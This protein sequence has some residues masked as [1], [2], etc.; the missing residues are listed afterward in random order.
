M[1]AHQENGVNQ[2]TSESTTDLSQRT[3]NGQG[4]AP[5]ADGSNLDKVRDILFGNQ[6]REYDKRFSRLE[7]RVIKECATVRDDTRKRLDS[8]E[9]FLKNEL[10][11][12]S[13]RLKHEHSTRDEA[14]K[15]L[16]QESKEMTASLER[17]FTQFDEQTSNSQREV[18]QHILDQSKSLYDEIRQ[19]TNEMLAALEREAQE[20]RHD[21]T[22]SSTL[23]ALFTELAIRL[24]HKS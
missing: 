6:V 17:K 11:S 18:R 8:L 12:L 21:K 16:A 20:L 14:V 15:A 5:A 19:K 23:A 13:E 9:S 1:N 7:E 10:E 2:I 22:D 4:T 24:N 3:N